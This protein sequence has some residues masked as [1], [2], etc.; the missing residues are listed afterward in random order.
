MYFVGFVVGLGRGSGKQE[1]RALKGLKTD[2][3]AAQTRCRKHF[4]LD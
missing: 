2:D 3:R 1:T 4:P